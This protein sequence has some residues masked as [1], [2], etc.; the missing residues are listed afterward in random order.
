MLLLLLQLYVGP[1]DV[2]TPN[3]ATASDFDG[4]LNFC[5]GYYT[6]TRYEAN[7]NG[8][9][10]DHPGA[11]INFLVHLGELT[12]V[13][14]GKHIVVRLDS[15]LL[16]NCPVLFMEDVGTIGLSLAESAGL[17]NYLLKGGL[18]WVDDFWGSDAWDQWIRTLKIAVPEARSV[19]IDKEHPIF[20]QQYNIPGIWQMPN[21]ALWNSPGKDG[22][23]VTSER[24]DSAVPVIQG[25]I[26]EKDRIIVLMTFNTDI[27]DGWEEEGTLGSA[28]YMRE[29]SWRS[30]ALG[31]NVFL[32]ALTR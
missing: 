32:Y 14:P 3:W 25:M 2:S 31:I 27:A 7:G 26:D 1:S 22:V 29:F 13:R 17:R 9:Y 20:H 23:R 4:R 5:R 11:D 21:V 15:P 24:Y 30:Y 6:S 19:S 12:T 8:W 18:L 10:T 28:E 16:M